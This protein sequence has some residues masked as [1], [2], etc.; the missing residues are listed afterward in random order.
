MNPTAVRAL[1]MVHGLTQTALS[2]RAGVSQ[3]TISRVENGELRPAPRTAVAL[4][5]ALGVPL[6][7]LIDKDALLADAVAGLERR[8]GA[9]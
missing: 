6:S 8:A 2:Q 5:A 4:A 1:R 3:P 7:S 9:R